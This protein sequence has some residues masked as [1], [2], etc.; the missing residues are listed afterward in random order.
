MRMFTI[1][2]PPK[3]SWAYQVK[4]DGMGGACGT[5]GRKEKRI[6]FWPENPKERGNLEHVVGGYYSNVS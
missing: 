6:M 4:A 2:T 5:R 1:C 3:C